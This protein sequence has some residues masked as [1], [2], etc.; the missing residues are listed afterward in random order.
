M[1]GI[2]KRGELV[3]GAE[4]KKNGVYKGDFKNGKKNGNGSY[5]W[6]NGETY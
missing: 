2:W 4:L 5:E 3:E 6:I 1:E